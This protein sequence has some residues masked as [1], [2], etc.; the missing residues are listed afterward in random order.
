MTTVRLLAS[1]ILLASWGAAQQIPIKN[2][3]GF[4]VAV[5]VA[6]NVT[7]PN[8]VNSAIV[9]PNGIVRV[10]N[11]ANTA[12]GLMLETHYYVY[13]TPKDAV[14]N[15][16]DNRWWGTGP[17]VSAQPGSSQIIQAVGAGWMVG[18]RRPKGSTPSGFGIGI[19][20]EAIP[21]AQ[22][23]GSEFVDGKPAPLGPSGQPLPIRYETQDK[24][25]L[26]VIFT[27]SF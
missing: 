3:F 11:R 26:L 27:V 9:D 8:L 13:P 5:G 19:G 15:G 7:G 14:S 23:L 22:V 16:V 12:A 2:D 4:G 25:A 24:G 1:I 18:F 17:F 21:S 20:Y 6:T 10:N